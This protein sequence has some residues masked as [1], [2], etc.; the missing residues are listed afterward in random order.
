M[1]LNSQ[2]QTYQILTND[3]QMLILC[4]S[5]FI[6]TVSV[7]S[8]RYMRFFVQLQ[9]LGLTAWHPRSLANQLTLFK[10]GGQIMPTTLL[11][12]TCGS[13]ILSQALHLLIPEN[14]WLLNF[15]KSK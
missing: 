11:L 8:G 1:A 9:F 14:S 5:Y 6:T 2:L 3:Y 7:R 12:G 13:K 10:P 15:F 4:H